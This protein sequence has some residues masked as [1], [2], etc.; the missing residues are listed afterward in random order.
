MKKLAV[1]AEGISASL[2]KVSVL[3]GI[4]VDIHAGRWTS[5]V[6]PNG[7]GKSTLLKVLAGL[8]P[9]T[10]TVTLHGQN[11]A[12]MPARQRA[13]TLAWLGQGEA[14]ADDLSVWDVALLGRIP[15]RPWLAAPSAQDLAAVEQALRATQAWDWR[16]RSLGQ[17]SGGERQRVLLARALAVQAPVLLMDEPL[18]NLDPPHQADW[19]LLVRDLVARGHTVVSVLHELSIALQ[20][21]DL[22][23]L[24]QGRIT[25]AGPC[26]DP[27][28]H[29]ALEQVFEHRIGI[30]RLSDQWVALPK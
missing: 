15:H 1:C 18:A 20:A 23:V 27:A 25:H 11:I 26:A 29:R 2:S 6:G 13:Q 10:G 7:A 16:A 9:F 30:H 3:H 21:D 14:S 24:A 28:T 5:I 12:T 19:L 8:L 17:L 4:S 22:L